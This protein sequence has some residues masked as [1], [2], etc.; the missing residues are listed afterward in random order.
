MPSP[1]I[2]EL[3]FSNEPMRAHTDRHKH[4]VY[5]MIYVTKGALLCEIAGNRI[6][7]E[8][9][10][11]LFVGNYEPHIISSKEEY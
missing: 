3:Y 7:C 11:V 4:N 8:A 1:L 5:Q 6:T 2:K 10:A 9:P